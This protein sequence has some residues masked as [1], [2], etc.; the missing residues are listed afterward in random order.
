LLTQANPGSARARSLTFEGDRWPQREN[1]DTG[2]HRQRQGKI[3]DLDGRCL[4][5]VNTGGS[6]AAPVQA[7]WP[8]GKIA[9]AG[10]HRQRQDKIADLRERSLTQTNVGSASRRLKIK[11]RWPQWQAD[12]S[13]GQILPNPP[14][15]TKS[16]QR[17]ITRH[18][19]CF[20]KTP[21]W[22]ANDDL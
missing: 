11:D 18:L 15:S 19:R 21:K 10:K 12:G 1:A 16:I 6:S 22:W 9:D 3:A 2:Q 7:C 8:Q 14:K 4:T 20:S 5:R 13:P 17:S